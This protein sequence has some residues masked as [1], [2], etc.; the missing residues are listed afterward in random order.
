MDSPAAV[1]QLE[2]NMAELKPHEQRVVAEK[3]E[4]DEKITKLKAFM[5]SETGLS[6]PA[7]DHG[8]L[9]QQAEAMESYSWF[10]GLRIR[11]FT[12]T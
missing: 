7:I 11:R 1:S 8:L 5:K 3:A 9:R 10:L 2:R 4:L 12:T 6:I